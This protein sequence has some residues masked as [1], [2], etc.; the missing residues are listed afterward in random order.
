MS[1]KQTVKDSKMIL[2][3]PMNGGFGEG[4]NTEYLYYREKEIK[5]E[6]KYLQK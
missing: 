5:Y 4:E 2:K 1:S 3:L 6:T